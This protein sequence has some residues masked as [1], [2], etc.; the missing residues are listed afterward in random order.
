MEVNYTED[1]GICR[2]D[3]LVRGNVAVL[4]A[5]KKRGRGKDLGMENYP[6]ANKTNERTNGQPCVG[7][8]RASTSDRREDKKEEE[9][10]FIT[11]GVG[12]GGGGL[13]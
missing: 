2:L 7:W 9:E 13:Y 6:N 11:S 8:F 5:Q 1:A 3:K 12:G 10:E 4:D